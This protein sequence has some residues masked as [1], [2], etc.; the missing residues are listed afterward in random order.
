MNK[1]NDEMLSILREIEKWTRVQAFDLLRRK[2]REFEKTD[3]AIYELS[4]ESNSVR[5]IADKL[6]VSR[7]KIAD[8]KK[9]FYKMGLMDKTTVRGGNNRF[10]HLAPLEGLGLEPPEE[11]M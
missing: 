6:E 2:L 9:S 7:S 10:V 5:D 8:R 11:A 3:L 4:T 1:K